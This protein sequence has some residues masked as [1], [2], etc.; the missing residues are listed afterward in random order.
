MQRRKQRTLQDGFILFLS[1]IVLVFVSV[2]F[3]VALRRY[4]DDRAI[5]LNSVI[6]CAVD[7][8]QQALGIQDAIRQDKEEIESQL[9]EC[10]AARERIEEAEFTPEFVE[11]YRQINQT[12]IA[13]NASCTQQI[14][15]LSATLAQLINGINA[16]ASVVGTGACQF[17][18]TRPTNETLPIQT[19]TFE[20]KRL[21]LNEL[22]FYYYVFGANSGPPL[23]V[24]DYGARL[25]NCSPIIFK[26]RAQQSKTLFY[27]GTNLEPSDYVRELVLGKNRLELRPNPGPQ[28]NQTLAITAGFQVFLDFF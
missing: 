1:I 13:A 26:S 28:L 10:E 22:E 18:T 19:V 23:L 25:E 24:E 9:T 7:N 17:T 15:T 5:T 27:N 16:T 2:A 6:D 12:I 21:V 4:L 14:E 20:Y 8:T 11:A 3:F